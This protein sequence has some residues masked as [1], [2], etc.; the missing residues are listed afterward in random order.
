MFFIWHFAD[1]V[2]IGLPESQHAPHFLK[3]V[4]MMLPCNNP[5]TKLL[6]YF[7]RSTVKPKNQAWPED[8]D[9][10]HVLVKS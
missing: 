7:R 4:S 5:E 10:L 3:K 2:K 1:S 6:T 9:I 8:A